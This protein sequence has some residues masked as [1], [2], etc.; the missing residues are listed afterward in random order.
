MD[1]EPLLTPLNTYIPSN[2]SLGLVQFGAECFRSVQNS[3]WIVSD[4][5]LSINSDSK[6]KAIP[7]TTNGPARTTATATGTDSSGTP[8]ASTT[9]KAGSI[10]LQSNYLLSIV[11]GGLGIFVGYVI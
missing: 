6:A 2:A 3:T 5:S 11:I 10:S 7:T 4:Y 8:G 1:I 9:K